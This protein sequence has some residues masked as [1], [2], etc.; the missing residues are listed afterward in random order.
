MQ[1]AFFGACGEVTGS[2]FILEAA[3]HKILFECGLF[4]GGRE[5]EKLNYQNFPYEPCAISALVVC[6][7]HLDH[8]G[9][10]PRLVKEGFR[11]RIYSTAPT[12]ELAHLVL[13]DN[14]K[15]M[16]E[17]ARKNNHP[18][19]YEKEDILRALALFECIDYSETVEI[20]PG[21]KITF[22]NAGHILGS[23]VVIIEAEGRK[24]LY[25]SDLGNNP[26]E[27]LNPPDKISDADFVICE[28]TYGGR[29][30]EDISLRRQK[31]SEVLNSTISQNGVMIIPSFAIERTQELL[32]DIEEFCTVNG[33]IK[34]TFYLDS[35]LAEK[36]TS[37]FKKYPEFLSS[38]LRSEH[39]D[40]D[41][42]GLGRVKFAG[43]VDDSKAINDAPTPKVIIA[44]SGMMNGGRILFHAERYLPDLKNTLLIVGYQATGTLGRRLFEGAKM[45]RIFGKNIEVNAQ[46]K[47]I[48]SYSAHADMPQLLEYIGSISNTRQVFITHGEIDQSEILK[49][50]IEEKLKISAIIP[51]KG[52]IYNL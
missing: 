43:S 40:N 10:I 19:L 45:V 37:V 38:K 28:S 30:H 48:G 49:Q 24:L 17:E 2:N 20:S 51:E 6:H 23:A 8:V 1:I 47:S 13:E 46:V 31:L 29:V 15:L 41:F 4:Q 22:K 50:V 39:E 3:G 14:Q 27:L 33:C 25:T 9:R 35:P 16:S 7:A 21:I 26:S 12:K 42:F 18:V 5:N 52:E 32:H 36:V 34:P 44:G 11:G